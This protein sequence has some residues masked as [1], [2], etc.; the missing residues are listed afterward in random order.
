M[1]PQ[2]HSFF[3]N[4]LIELFCCRKKPTSH[5]TNIDYAKMAEDWSWLTNEPI[6]DDNVYG[7]MAVTNADTVQSSYLI[8]M[9]EF[10]DSTCIYIFIFFSAEKPSI[11]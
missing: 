5:K 11:L 4:N 9:D 6:T 8:I 1:R 2:Q 3:Q 7:L 10:V